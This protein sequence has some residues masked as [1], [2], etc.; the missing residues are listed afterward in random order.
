MKE[1]SVYIDQEDGINGFI[2]KAKNKRDLSAKL[3]RMFPDDIGADAY[4]NDPDTDEEF[5]INWGISC[6]S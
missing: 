2:I 1:Y 3:R 4:G 5:G 6:K